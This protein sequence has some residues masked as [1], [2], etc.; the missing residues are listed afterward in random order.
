MY[1][2]TYIYMIHPIN[3][4]HKKPGIIVYLYIYIYVNIYICDLGQITDF[5][6]RSYRVYDDDDD[7]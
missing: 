4:R 5:K 1:I 2:Y 6:T 7:V 3:H